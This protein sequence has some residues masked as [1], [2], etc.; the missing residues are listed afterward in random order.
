METVFPLDANARA[1]T[2]VRLCNVAADHDPVN[3]IGTLMP[4]WEIAWSS[5]TV[6][7]PNFTFVA[8]NAEKNIYGLTTRGSVT[9]KFYTPWDLFVDWILEDA[10]IKPV[11]WHYAGSSKTAT[12]GNGVHIAFEVLQF[13]GNAVGHGESLLDFLIT[14]T[15]NKNKQLIIAGHSLGGNISKVYASFYI[16]MLK[17]FKQP[18]DNIFLNT[19]AAPASGNSDFQKDLDSKSPGAMHFQNTNDLVPALPVAKGIAALGNL[20]KPFPKATDIQVKSDGKEIPLSLF[21]VGM[22]SKIAPLD[23]QQPNDS[24]VTTFAAPLVNPPDTSTLPLFEEQGAMQHQLFNYATYL[25]VKLPPVNVNDAIA[26]AI[27]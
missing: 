24:L 23:Y 10:N 25:G 2:A 12:I 19:F 22:A 13:A 27:L 7:D 5:G 3:N 11:P 26:T 14:N 17:K 9:G 16:E 1:Q 8:V 4:G 21:F 20:Y 15:I 6:K 18:T